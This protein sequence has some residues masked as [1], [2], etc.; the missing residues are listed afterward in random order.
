MAGGCAA[1]ALLVACERPPPPVPQAAHEVG[2]PKGWADDLA[3]PQPL[4]VN[5]DPHVLE[6]NLEAKIVELEIVPGHKTTVWTYNGNI[7]GPLIRGQVGDRVIV[8]FKN[9]LPEATTIHWHGLRLPNNMDGAPGATQDPIPPGGEFTYDFT[10]RDA[11]TYWYHPHVDSS[12]QVGRGLYGAILVEDPND[13]KAFGDDLVLLLSDMSLDDDG[14]MLPADSGGNFGDLFGREGSVL[15][16]NG[17]VLPTLKVRAGKQQ[18]WRIINA[19]RAR[20]YNVRLRDHR[21]MRL[22]GDNGLAARSTDTYALLVT[23]GE[24]SRRRL[25]ARERP[26]YSSNVLR[27][28]PT[29]RGYGSTFNRASV[30]MLKIETVADAAVTPEPIPTE[31]R[32]IEPIDVTG[33]T[34]A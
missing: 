19:T 24:T 33:A 11:G 27:W 8:H 30:D 9:S 1:L 10:L 25:H 29:E 20:Y 15:L 16:V 34:R 21:F 26:R 4:D 6:F 2:Q 22:G 14:E 13:P 32:T 31:L 28:V 23:P 12:A 18:R 3:M 5:P 17:K 7:P